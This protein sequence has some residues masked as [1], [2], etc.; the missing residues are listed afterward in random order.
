MRYTN[1]ACLTDNVLWLRDTSPAYLIDNGRTFIPGFATVTVVDVDNGRPQKAQ[2]LLLLCPL[3]RNP[4]LARLEY[5]LGKRS[6]SATCRLSPS[7]LFFFP[8]GAVW[9]RCILG[10]CCENHSSKSSTVISTIFSRQNSMAAQISGL[11]IS[12]SR[13]L[14]NTLKKVLLLSCWPAPSIY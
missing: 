11:Q 13:S 9:G 1:P 14:S 6:L 2:P 10:N 8:T 5:A 12:H 3:G 7:L 4:L